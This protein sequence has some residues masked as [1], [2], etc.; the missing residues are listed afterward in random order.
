M[1][2]AAMATNSSR[3]EV[4]RVT[5]NTEWRGGRMGDTMTGGQTLFQPGDQ[6]T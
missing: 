5:E 4:W 3:V 1:L 6:M 2:V